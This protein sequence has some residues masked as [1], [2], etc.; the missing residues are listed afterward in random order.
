[1]HIQFSVLS[2]LY[3]LD[4][5][6]HAKLHSLH[7]ISR[8]R[9]HIPVL[10][11]P[12]LPQHDDAVFS[13]QY[14]RLMLMF[15]KPWHS[16]SD[17]IHS[18]QDWQQSF[19]T[20]NLSGSCSVE[21]HA[22]MDNMQMIHAC[23]AAQDSHHAN[24]FKRDSVINE[25]NER[26][27]VLSDDVQAEDEEFITEIIQAADNMNLMRNSVI[28]KIFITMQISIS[29]TFN[30]MTQTSQALLRIP[31]WEIT[32]KKFYETQKAQWRQEQK[33]T[34]TNKPL[35]SNPSSIHTQCIV[36]ITH[37]TIPSI[38]CDTSP[39]NILHSPPKTDNDQII[40]L[41]GKWMLNDKQAMAFQLIVKHAL[42]TTNEAPL[43]MFIGGLA[44]TGKSH[45]I[46]ATWDFFQSQG[47]E[48]C[49]KLLAFMGIA[50]SNIQG[51][52]I[53]STLCLR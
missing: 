42:L 49:I 43:K 52:T 25:T 50:A 45:V 37:P 19:H 29:L 4:Q 15:F 22:V 2:I 10:I 1:M 9:Q 47:E 41:I 46:D 28:S 16:P 20:C 13:E 33:M 17:L 44:G 7:V 23:K 24:W 36:P 40:S 6:V 51:M 12:S 48:Q 31:K 53:H 39:I 26:N 34:A 27:A 35:T 21:H 14:A 38:M 11:S 3:F 5:H 30:P 32:W 18:N 8:R